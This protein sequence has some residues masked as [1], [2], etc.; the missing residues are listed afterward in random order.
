MQSVNIIDMEPNYQQTTPG[1]FNEQRPLPN[2]TTTLVLGILSIVV[3]FICG[4]VA[5]VI[6]N[7]DKRM[8]EENP[9]MYSASSYE[10]L[11]A[12]RICAIISLCLVGLVVF[13][14]IAALMF[15]LTF[16]TFNND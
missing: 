12:G 2:A 15:G 1:L 11:R 14:F 16:A 8:Y 7:N 6:S 9:Q 4:I 3:C 13:F 10:T 5:L